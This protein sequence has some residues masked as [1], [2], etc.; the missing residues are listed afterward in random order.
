MLQPMAEVYLVNGDF[1]TQ[2][3]R[4]PNARAVAV[5]SGRFRAVGDEA[6]IRGLATADAQIIDLEG[7]L[8]LPGLTDA[9]FHCYDWALGLQRLPLADA[10]SLADLC[11]RVAQEASKTPRD[12]W[13]LG[14][15][16]NETCWP[17]ARFPTRQDL[18]AA[19]PAHP[20]LLWR[21]DMHLAVANSKALRRAG[22]TA[23]TQA[24]PDGTLDRDGS[25]ELTGVLRELA[26][27]LVSDNIPPPSDDETVRALRECFPL[28]HRLGLTGVHDFRI[29]DGSDGPPAFRA[30]QRLQAAGQLP[31]RL[32][33]NLPGNRLTEAIALG[34]R[35]GFGDGH[36]CVGHVKVF[37]D[38]AQGALTAWML[39]P[40]L[41]EDYCGMPLTP[42][43]KIADAIRRADQAGLALAVHAIGDRANR[44]LLSILEQMQR[45][46][47]HDARPV[48]SHV[49]HR[50]EHV[51][52]IQSQ[53]VARLARLGVVASVQPIHATDDIA[54]IER[55][56]GQRACFAY[57]FRDLWDAGVVLALGSD[58]P[59]ADPNPLWGIHAAATR[60]RRDG[61]PP[62][63]W[64][65]GQRL[66]VAEAVWGFT[67]GPALATG[68][69]NELGSISPGKRA[70]L[71]VL[72]R[73]IF[74]IDPGEIAHAQVV[75]TVLDGE[76]VYRR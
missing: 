61:T 1:Y 66:T 67:M 34:L 4:H 38:G 30:Y 69:Q 74:A 76:V 60:Q 46:R 28:L 50:I 54:M 33:M 56:V 3:P 42:M 57:R 21:S 14:Q 59:V 29:M 48:P 12:Q 22:V 45:E 52:N 32:W 68:R 19:A 16:W 63:G 20:V 62:G 55:T 35:T 72:D 41:G 51:Q 73:D 65:P 37:S 23:N 6:Q 49:P 5:R 10:A 8:V 44:E 71:V 15:G 47:R 17:V 2:D 18:D 36:L 9:H 58:C 7:R 11:Q 75:M 43:D 39:E 70:D 31:L 53:D 13:L 64:Y 40:Y 27:G 25:G 24:P 26:I